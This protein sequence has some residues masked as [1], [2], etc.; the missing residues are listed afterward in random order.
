M[1]APELGRLAG[2]HRVQLI[3]ALIGVGFWPFWE[4]LA[5]ERRASPEQAQVIV[6]TLLTAS[7][8]RSE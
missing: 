4:S 3:S 1:F 8:I 5:D 6:A 7:L 2:Q